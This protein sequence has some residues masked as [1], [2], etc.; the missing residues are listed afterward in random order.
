MNYFY[1][2]IVV[3][4]DQEYQYLMKYWAII[5]FLFFVLIQLIYLA[6]EI[7][8]KLDFCLCYLFLIKH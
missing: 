7:D 2:Y 3:N 6:N 4:R 5:L 1:W 8:L